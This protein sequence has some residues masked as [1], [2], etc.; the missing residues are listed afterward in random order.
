MFYYDDSRVGGI[1]LCLCLFILGVPKFIDEL[2]QYK[3]ASYEKNTQKANSRILRMS[4]SGGLILAG[5]FGVIFLILNWSN[6]N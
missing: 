4:R 5:I 6:L 2:Y 1:I 3:M